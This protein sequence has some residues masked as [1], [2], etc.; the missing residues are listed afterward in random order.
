MLNRAQLLQGTQTLPKQAGVPPLHAVPQA[1]QWLLSFVRLTHW[2]LQAVCP[3]PQLI[4]QA[5]PLQTWP[6]AHAVPQE[7]QLLVSDARLAQ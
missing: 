5:E 6:A 7:P 1:P 2:P 3:P 4:A